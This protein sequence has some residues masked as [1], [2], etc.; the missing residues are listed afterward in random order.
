MFSKRIAEINIYILLPSAA[1]ISQID[2][3]ANNEPG[4]NSM[5]LTSAG[6]MSTPFRLPPA[7]RTSSLNKCTWAP[8]KEDC[9]LFN[10]SP[11][12]NSSHP[13]SSD[14]FPLSTINIDLLGALLRSISRWLSSIFC[15]R[16]HSIIQLYL[17]CTHSS[18]LQLT[19]LT[20]RGNSAFQQSVH[21][22]MPRN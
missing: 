16:I 1:T 2:M 6:R 9:P 3:L 19:P 10:Y 5:L 12:T 17:D 8:L 18:A 20:H 11:L 22:I 4:N 14:S 21:Q 13:P 7:W 15:Q